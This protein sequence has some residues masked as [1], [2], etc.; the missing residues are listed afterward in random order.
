MTALSFDFVA[1]VVV[2]MPVRM[3][4]RVDDPAVRVT[5]SVH[6]VNLG[7]QILVR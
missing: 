5:V 3:G 7:E 4:V 2:Q 1:V 6:Q